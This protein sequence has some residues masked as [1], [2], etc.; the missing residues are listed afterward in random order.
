MAFHVAWDTETER[1]GPGRQAPPLACVSVKFAGGV[2]LIHWT[3]AQQF[4][5]QVLYDPDYILV[6][7]NIAYDLAVVAAQ[8]PK[9][10]PAIFQLFEDGRVRDTMIRQKLLDIAMG[11]FRGYYDEPTKEERE[12]GYKRGQWVKLNYDLSDCHYRYTKRRLEKD[13]WRKKYGLFRHKPLHLWPSGARKYAKD[14]AKAT[15]TVYWAQEHVCELLTNEVRS[16]IPRIADPQPLGDEQSQCQAL[17]WM[18]LMRTWGIRT[19]PRKVYKLKKEAQ[20][21]Y[22]ALVHEL[23]HEPLC[24]VCSRELKKNRCSAHG[25]TP[26]VRRDV[27]KKK[28]GEEMITEIKVSRHKKPL[29]LVRLDGSRDT[30]VAKR[31]MALVMGGVGNCRR[32]KKSKSHPLGQIQLDEDAC[33]ASGDELLKKYSELTK[34]SSVVK[35]DIPALLKGRYL[36]IHSNFNSLIATG[37]TSSSKPNIQ[38][39]RRLPGIRECFEPREGKVFLDADYDGLELRTLAQ[40]CIKIVGFSKL[41]DVL[42]AG[43]DPHLS[44]AA[45]ILDISYEEAYRRNERGDQEVDDARQT[46]KV[47]NFGF[48]GGLGYEALVSFAWKI[49]GVKITEERAKWL[50]KQW[51]IT[52]PEME[53]YFSHINRLCQEDPIE[54]LAVIEQLFTKRIRGNIRYT[55]A[56]NSY[57]QGLGSDATKRAGWLLAKACYV[58]KESP[59]YGCRIVNYI[60][61]QFLIECDEDRAHE[62]CMEMKRLMV[63]GAKPYLPDVPP[64]VKKP[65][66]ARCW[67]K[68]AQQVWEQ[69]C[70]KC[71]EPVRYMNQEVRGGRVTCKAC[72][73]STK[74]SKHAKL[75]P[76]DEEKEK[77]KSRSK[78]SVKKAA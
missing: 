7:H 51:M 68:K 11:I 14:D 10:L 21:A 31:R 37:R 42:N 70:R 18:N 58:D 41:A 30:G 53:Q 6:G 44:V 60:H 73:S 23:Q 5:D 46:A 43:R 9:Y 17:W 4:F 65:V 3:E 36:P 39:I 22:D 75:V 52:F 29:T 13:Q 64:T 20:K 16:S 28:V 49:Y 67:S 26:W 72:K 40:V 76:W 32:T 1:F 47:A 59:L 48:P 45:Q 56:C 19:N 50:K 55:V 27:T 15:W 77:S 71:H 61:D 34:R 38:N 24:P 62:A 2:Q 35:K 78:R 25:G 69:E 8:F 66:V 54:N 74:V 57:F 33:V 63:E 12:E